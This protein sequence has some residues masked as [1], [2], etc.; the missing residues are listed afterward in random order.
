MF[1]ILLVPLFMFT[2][3]EET[4]SKTEISVNTSKFISY[5]FYNP[6]VMSSF[7]WPFYP[8]EL[9]PPTL[10]RVY[11]F[12]QKTPIDSLDN[13]MFWRFSKNNQ[14]NTNCVSASLFSSLLSLQMNQFHITLIN[15]FSLIHLQIHKS[16]TKM[17]P[18]KSL[19][20]WRI[21]FTL[22]LNLSYTIISY[23]F[24]HLTI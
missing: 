21:I 2:I 11:V 16:L 13:A 24:L 6:Q 22:I 23:Y 7:L 9:P 19:W 4:F 3:T 5:L 18:K 14:N 15:H 12:W 10:H 1:T 20:Q 8:Y 17:N